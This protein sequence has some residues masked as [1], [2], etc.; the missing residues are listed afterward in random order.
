MFQGNNCNVELFLKA[1][2]VRL[3]LPLAG[4]YIFI[5]CQSSAC[6][7]SLR[8]GGAFL[9]RHFFPPNHTLEGLQ[10]PICLLNLLNVLKNNLVICTDKLCKIKEKMPGIPT[11]PAGAL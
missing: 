9:M 10:N 4:W 6:S 2:N 7:Q 1:L 5:V 11:L 8:V 3:F